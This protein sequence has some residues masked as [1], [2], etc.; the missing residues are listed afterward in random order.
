MRPRPHN[1]PLPLACALLALLSCACAPAIRAAGGAPS[2]A[3]AT[4]QA[5]PVQVVVTSAPSAPP[6]PAASPSPAAALRYDQM[7][8]EAVL[9]LLLQ[10]EGD[11]SAVPLKD[12][13]SVSLAQGSAV[14]T[15]G[16]VCTVDLSS[17]ALQMGIHELYTVCLSIATTLCALPDVRFV[18]ILV[19]GN[20]VAMD[21]Q[22]S[23]IHI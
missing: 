16:H 22:L 17:A 1:R 2:I 9:Q 4:P 18:N 11:G 7:P 14:T 23:L 3:A 12:Y 13:G 20:P 19:A 15:A 5:V 10:E 6:L 21:V 8:A